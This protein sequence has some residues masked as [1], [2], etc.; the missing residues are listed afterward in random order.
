MASILPQTSTFLY[1]PYE[2]D[3]TDA[4]NDPLVGQLKA[5]VDPTQLSLG[6][7]AN[8]IPEG[9]ITLP[10][11]LTTSKKKRG[12]LPRHVVLSAL[13][14][15]KTKASIVKV[16]ILARITAIDLLD[17]NDV[18]NDDFFTYAGFAGTL[19]IQNYVQESY[20]RV[21]ETPQ[22]ASTLLRSAVVPGPDNPGSSRS[23]I[24]ETRKDRKR[25]LRS[26]RYL[27]A[28]SNEQY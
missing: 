4:N 13:P 19:T 7:A 26:Q 21:Y 9:D 5:L 24:T 15:G 27:N 17:F 10:Y 12:I 28:L 6:G 25:R 8:S 22:S 18:L 20:F 14:T 3:L 23:E 2:C 11:P 1:Y 16:V